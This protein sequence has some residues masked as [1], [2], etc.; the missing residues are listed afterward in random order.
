MSARRPSSSRRLPAA[1]AFTLIEVVLA[2]AAFAIILVAVHGVFYNAIR[3]RDRTTLSLDAALPLQRTLALLQRDLANLVPPGGTLSGTLQT[4]PTDDSTNTSTLNTAGSADVRSG[5]QRVS[6]DLYAAVG[7]LGDDLPWAEVQRVTYYLMPSTNRTAV[8]R[9][10]VR[11]VTRNLLPPNQEEW[12]EDRLLTEV[13]DV[14]FYFYDGTEWL[15]TW[16]STTEET[17]LPLAVRV[18]LT[19]S[20]EV[21]GLRR[22]EPIELVVPVMVVVQTNTTAEA[23]SSESSSSGGS[24]GG[25]SGGRPGGGS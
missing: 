8:G 1:R 18:A 13:E 22:P 16:D 4:T 9:D 2:T 17:P 20:L 15:E 7:V 19:R 12:T 3:L 25:G 14:R 21:A 5:A 11:S 24:S 10:L 23:A 6:P